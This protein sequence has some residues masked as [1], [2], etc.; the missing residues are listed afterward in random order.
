MPGGWRA[1]IYGSIKG[2]GKT[3]MIG[4]MRGDELIIS[5][6]RTTLPGCLYDLIAELPDLKR[7]YKVAK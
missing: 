4:V 5:I 7:Q 2:D 1:E 6:H 3:V